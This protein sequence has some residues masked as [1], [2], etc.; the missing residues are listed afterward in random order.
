MWKGVVLYAV[1]TP[2]TEARASFSGNLSEKFK[3]G[4]SGIIFVLRHGRPG[5]LLPYLLSRG[6]K[7]AR[8][9]LASS[10][11]SVPGKIADGPTP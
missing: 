9:S 1:P 2:K 5:R 4:D 7:T 8:P 11:A 3:M 10:A 6:K